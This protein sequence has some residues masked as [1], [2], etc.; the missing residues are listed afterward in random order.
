MH[1]YE[2]FVYV[3]HMLP[4]WRSE[5]PDYYLQTIDHDYRLLKSTMPWEEDPRLEPYVRQVVEVQGRVNDSDEIEVE[6]IR[7]LGRELI[8]S[9]AGN[10]RLVS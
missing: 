2:G 5:G 8:G 7:Q 4:G 6:S 9:G 3:K 10:D 1:A